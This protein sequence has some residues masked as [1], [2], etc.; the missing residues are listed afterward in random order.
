MTPRNHKAI[1][2]PDGSSLEVYADGQRRVV[3]LDFC[4]WDFI[5]AAR[6]AEVS[7]ALDVERS[8]GGGRA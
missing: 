4:I 3:A 1:I 8:L 7:E 5:E 6:D 2:A